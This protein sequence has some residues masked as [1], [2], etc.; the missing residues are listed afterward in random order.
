MFL[1]V[2]VG[3]TAVVPQQFSVHAE[4]RKKPALPVLISARPLAPLPTKHRQQGLRMMA[5][6]AAASCALSGWECGAAAQH[7]PVDD[8]APRLQVSL[9]SGLP[10]DLRNLCMKVSRDKQ[11]CRAVLLVYPPGSGGTPRLTTRITLTPHNPWTLGSVHAT[12]L[13]CNSR[14]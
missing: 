5:S 11:G 10:G 4:L 12:R 13:P 3:V 8:H 6:P 2:V 9:Q 7:E 1:V 14:Q